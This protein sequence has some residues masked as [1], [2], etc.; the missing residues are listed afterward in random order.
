MSSEEQGVGEEKLSSSGNQR[1][2]AT[3]ARTPDVFQRMQHIFA[4]Y[5]V[6][7]LLI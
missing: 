3:L 2:K 7:A 4:V 6:P 1:P 5:T